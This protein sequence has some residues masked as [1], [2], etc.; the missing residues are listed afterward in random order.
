MIIGAGPW[1]EQIEVVRA[2]NEAG[3][4]YEVR[5]VLDD[6]PDL[7]GETVEGS[8]VIGTL[9][10]ARAV[11][12]VSF[13]LA[14]GANKNRLTLH[15]LLERIAVPPERF[16]S[17]IHPSATVYESADVGAGAIVHAG[18]VIGQGARIGAFA[19]V[20]WNAVVGADNLIGRG[21]VLCPLAATCSR[22]KVGPFA[23][24][25]TQASVADGCEVGPM[26]AIGLGTAASRDVRPGETVYGMPPRT[27]DR[28]EV[29][30][31]IL[32]EWEGDKRARST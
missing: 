14:I 4:G 16:P 6:D 31:Q 10:D 19:K 8:P 2:L 28:A 26:A 32:E 30:A 9:D 17:L 5:G 18:A 27:V 11:D 3:A 29:P 20:I 21:A 24:L 1:R 22:V 25:A 23:F 15:R 12:D 7:R 13:L